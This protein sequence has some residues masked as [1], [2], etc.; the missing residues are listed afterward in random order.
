MEWWE[1]SLLPSPDP[2][3]ALLGCFADTQDLVVCPCGKGLACPSAMGSSPSWSMP[4]WETHQIS[5]ISYQ[6]H[7]GGVFGA[8]PGS[9]IRCTCSLCI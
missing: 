5:P 8:S 9:V 6:S 7:T 3:L 1:G 2:L 4:W